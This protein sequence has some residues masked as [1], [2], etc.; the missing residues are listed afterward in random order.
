ML[1]DM[2]NEKIAKAGF[3]LMNL[4][5]TGTVAAI[6]FE[7]NILMYISNGLM[8]LSSLLFLKNMASIF[9]IKGVKNVK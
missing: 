9:L 3:I 1:K 6:A 5:L 4:A 8:F 7:N 2:F